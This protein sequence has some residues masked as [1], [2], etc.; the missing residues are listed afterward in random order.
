MSLICNSD[1]VIP[2]S[3]S[4]WCYADSEDVS[5]ALMP[6]RVS[7]VD[8]FAPVTYEA[9]PA[10]EWRRFTRTIYIPADTHIALA[11]TNIWL[12][13]AL[14]ASTNT[15]KVY[16]ALPMVTLG[17]TPSTWFPSAYD[18]FSEIS[19]VSSTA[20]SA[21]STANSAA[22][23]ASTA[24]TNA[25]NALNTANNKVSKSGDAMT[26]D[27]N[28][29]DNTIIIFAGDETDNTRI[30]L[31]DNGIGNCTF[32]EGGGDK[33]TVRFDSYIGISR[34]GFYDLDANTQ[35]TSSHL[36]QGDG[37]FRSIE[38][39]LTDSNNIPTSSAVKKLKVGGRN[40]LRGT[41][42]ITIA[43]ATGGYWYLSKF[44][45]S[46]TGSYS[47][48]SYTDGQLPIPGVTKT[49]KLTCPTGSTGFGIAQDK[50]KQT[51]TSSTLT[52]NVFNIGD[53]L[54]LS[55]WVKPSAA[56]VICLLQPL[57]DCKTNTT[58]GVD[59][60]LFTLSEGWQRIYYSGTLTS[61]NTLSTGFDIGYIY[62]KTPGASIEVCC[63]KL[64]F[65]EIPTDWTPALE[66][67]T[68]TNYGFALTSVGSTSAT[69]Y[70]WS[71]SSTDGSS[72]DYRYLNHTA[73][74]LSISIDPTTFQNYQYLIVVQSTNAC[75]ITLTCSSGGIFTKGNITSFT[76][77]AGQ[78]IEFSAVS[79]ASLQTYIT[80]TIFG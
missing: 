11:T 24:N 43:G 32:I 48:V 22:S 29:N 10:G 76:V 6:I 79:V 64:E 36:V 35:G 42:D 77:A 19:S 38:T 17:S 61:T 55:Y 5:I 21:L 28:M 73:S 51:G 49:A 4:I 63:P 46:G 44:R 74:T 72:S 20:S 56:G 67:T 23:T 80:Y 14:A 27:L 65:G 30:D 75:T 3:M 1:R 26:G 33:D 70:T 45:T 66:D 54:C 52:D 53:T 40:L 50:Y 59:N 39:T 9:L 71:L 37:H 62:C 41:K 31:N 2:V 34:Y 8:A 68:S 78:S 7:N 58:D 25:T 47:T 15:T 60:K 16:F 18:I 13:G 57:F 69:S 12:G